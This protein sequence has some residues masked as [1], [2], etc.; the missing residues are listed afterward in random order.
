MSHPLLHKIAW[1]AIL[2]ED[3]NAAMTKC[4]QAAFLQSQLQEYGLQLSPDVI[5]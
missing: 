2:L 1:H 4:M 5:F 3:R